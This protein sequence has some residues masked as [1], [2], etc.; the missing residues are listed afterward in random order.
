MSEGAVERIE[1]AY[2]AHF[3]ERQ[4]R[5]PGAGVSLRAITGAV[6]FAARTR[7]EVDWMNTAFVMGKLTPP[8]VEEIVAFYRE[9]GVRPRIEA[10]TG[11]PDGFVPGGELFVLA[12]VPLSE[13]GT[14]GKVEVRAVE[15]NTFGQFVDVYVEA[16]G[17]EDI[18]RT[19]VE[20]WFALEN[21]RFY[22][23]EVEGRPAGAGILSIHGDVAYLASAA[24][25]PGL[26]GRGV[27]SALLRRRI[28]DAASA[29]CSVVFGRAAPGGPGAAGL[30]RAGLMLSHRKRIWSEAR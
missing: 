19:D 11:E 5:L 6:L 30:M 8:L 16:F 23:A 25:L 4:S 1:R 28:S 24:T 15:R 29:G 13:G 27:H 9:Q 3:A 2:A 26:R 21:W 10:V 18:P 14:S 17:R 12:V 22:V 20:T 7:P